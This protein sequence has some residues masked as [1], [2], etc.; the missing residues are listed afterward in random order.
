MILTYFALGDNGNERS[1]TFILCIIALIAILTTIFISCSV[2]YLMRLRRTNNI[3]EWKE[4]SYEEFNYLSIQ[5]RQI[6]YN[7]ALDIFQSGDLSTEESRY[8]LKFIFKYIINTKSLNLY[9]RKKNY[10]S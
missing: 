7:N 3:L 5:N 8:Q 2:M 6:A 9:W 10:L 1:A 4:V